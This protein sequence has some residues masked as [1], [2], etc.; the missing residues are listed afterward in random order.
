MIQQIGGK[1]LLVEERRFSAI[2]NDTAKTNGK[3]D[4]VASVWYK[5]KL[6]LILLKQHCYSKKLWFRDMENGVSKPHIT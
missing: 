6:S 2:L 5:G 3:N 4:I 1:F